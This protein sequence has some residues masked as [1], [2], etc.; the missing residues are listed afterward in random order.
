MARIFLA[1]FLLTGFG[2]KAQPVLKG[3]LEN[4]V[5]NNKIYPLYSLQNCIQG[6]VT[7]G[8]KLN[9]KGEVFYSEVRRGLGTDLDDEALR[10]IRMSSGKWTMP[11]DHDST[12]VILAPINFKLSGYDC[13]NKSKE[14][15]RQAIRNY[16]TNQGLTDAVLNFYK[17]VKAGSKFT[18]EEENKIIAL[19][20]SLGYDDEYLNSRINDGKKKLKQK[21][22][23]GAC[24]DFLF[25]KYMGSDLADEL[26]AKYC[27]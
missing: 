6:G 21:D 13:A 15:I 16:K 27:N 22:K 10:L 24:E 19:K 7:I 8:F 11:Q 17:K 2:L 25:V 1:L 26:L 4:F 18:K 23:Q 20:K 3:G 14:E 9:N 5:A 12:V